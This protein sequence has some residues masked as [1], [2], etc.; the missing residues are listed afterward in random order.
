MCQSMRSRSVPE[1]PEPS[2]HEEREWHGSVPPVKIDAH[3]QI[4]ALAQLETPSQT[5][6]F[7]MGRP[8]AQ[9]AKRARA[10]LQ[11]AWWRD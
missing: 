11:N 2:V 5:A 4:D 10:A 3:G 1:K 9:S 6:L 8:S 7:N